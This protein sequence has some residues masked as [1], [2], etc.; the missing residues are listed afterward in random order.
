[1]RRPS[2]SYPGWLQ[3]APDEHLPIDLA[4][5]ALGLMAGL[6]VDLGAAGPNPDRP[7]IPTNRN[8]ST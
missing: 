6:S 3:H 2:H 8:A 5:E 4:Q 7:S 1:M